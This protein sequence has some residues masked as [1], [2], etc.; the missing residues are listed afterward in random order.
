MYALS[1][2][3]IDTDIDSM[4][5][6]G[7]PLVKFTR[8]DSKYASLTFENRQTREPVSLDTSSRYNQRS[9]LFQGKFNRK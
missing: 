1:A 5:E 4:E 9:T 8:T 3:M 2:R 7:N 6:G